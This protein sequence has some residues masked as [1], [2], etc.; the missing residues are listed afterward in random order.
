MS[1]YDGDVVLPAV[2]VT[3]LDQLLTYGF[4]ISTKSADS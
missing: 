2:V 4:E 1:Q 3:Q